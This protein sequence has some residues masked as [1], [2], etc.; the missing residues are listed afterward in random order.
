MIMI[1]LKIESAKHSKNQKRKRCAES[2][3]INRF[4]IPRISAGNSPIF[5][6]KEDGG[7]FI[8]GENKRAHSANFVT[9]IK[10]INNAIYNKQYSSRRD[11][12]G[13]Q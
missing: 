9:K 4:V 1:L 5:A 6:Y 13:E 8:T 3:V 12:Q 7:K 11:G 10:C 2:E